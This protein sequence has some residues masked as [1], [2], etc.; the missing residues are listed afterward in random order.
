MLVTTI[1]GKRTNA[2]VGVKDGVVLIGT[3]DAKPQLRK[4]WELLI[5]DY[6]HIFVKHSH[7]SNINDTIVTIIT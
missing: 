3:K 2:L 6:N 1:R 7:V 5:P 4:S